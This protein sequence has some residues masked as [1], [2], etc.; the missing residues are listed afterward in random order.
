MKKIC[1]VEGCNRKV[2][3]PRLSR[4]IKHQKEWRAEYYRNNKDKFRTNNNH[5]YDQDIIDRELK[6]GALPGGIYKGCTPDQI[7]AMKTGNVEMLRKLK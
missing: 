4:C 5:G 1:R 6:G 3:N 7:K 2:S